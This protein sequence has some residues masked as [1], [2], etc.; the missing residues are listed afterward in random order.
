MYSFTYP[1]VAAGDGTIEAVIPTHVVTG[2]LGAGKTTFLL[3]QVRRRPERC[4]V[5][6]NDFGDARIDAAAFEGRVPVI[7][8]PGG[9]VCCTAPEDLVPSVRMLI[10]TAAPERLFIEATGLARPADIVDTLVRSGLAIAVAPVICVVDPR[11]VSPDRPLLLEQIDA[12]D[13]VLANHASDASE[14]DFQALDEVLV[15]RYPPLLALERCDNG[16]VDLDV[17][18][19]RPQVLFLRAAEGGRST[20]DFEAATRAWPASKVFD[21]GALLKSLA[22]TDAERVKG[23]FKTDLGWFRIDR[24]SG[25]VHVVPSALRSGSAVDVIAVE[26]AQE[27]RE[28]LDGLDAAGVEEEGIRLGEH[29]L[30]RWALAALPGQVPDVSE[31]IP[32]KEGRGVL[33]SEILGLIDGERFIVVASDGMTTAPLPVSE[34]GRAVVVHSLSEDVALPEKL[35]GPYRILAPRGESCAN[36][37]GVAR[38]EVV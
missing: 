12:S 20:G 34:V 25:E 26:G 21:R 37:K 28:V 24:A 1:P 22:D 35:G 17:L 9:C 29:V 32:G 2:F 6:V 8:I 11:R 33:L 15:G 31:L 13:I 7:D 5:V 23:L 19:L 27:L 4:A 30:N 3:D 18:D 16:V 38:I 14:S 10:E 36:V